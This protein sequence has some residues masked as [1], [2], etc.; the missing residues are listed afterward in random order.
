MLKR[1]G[2]ILLLACACV[3]ALPE[4]AAAQRQ[5][6][7]FTIGY[8]TVR[9]ED[10]RL[11][12]DTLV[13][14]HDF[15]SFDFKD[16]NGATVGAEWLIPIGDYFEAGAGLGFYRRTVPSVYTNFVN[17]DGTEIDQELRLRIIP[18]TATIRVLPLGRSPVQPYLGVGV[19]LFNWR[20]SETGQFV[21]FSD[22]NSVFRASYVAS[23]NDVGPVAFGGLRFAG[24]SFSGGGEIRYQRAEGDLDNRFVGTKIDLGGWTYQFTFGFR[25]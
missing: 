3:A 22:N 16:F 21:D 11:A 1:T 15:L 19:G 17:T 7:N 25:F 12:G 9:G 4:P 20:Y 10:A 2:S 23:G 8:F 24:D 18:L 14:N 6:L 5:T 13:E